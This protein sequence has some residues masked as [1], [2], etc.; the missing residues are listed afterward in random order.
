VQDAATAAI[1]AHLPDPQGPTAA[2]VVLDH[3][4][5]HVIALI[6]GRDWNASKV[7]LARGVDGGGAGRQPGSSFK[8]FVLAAALVAGFRPDDPVPAP[9]SMAVDGADHP[10][11]NY[12]GAAY[13]TLN[14]T[15]ATVHS[16]N[17]S[18]T[19]LTQQVG[20]QAV[21]DMATAL[22]IG[23]LPASGLGASIGLGAY[24]TSP[25]DMAA[26][27]S[28][29]AEDG[30][31]VDPT[32]VAR[33]VGPDGKVLVDRTAPAPGPGVLDPAFCR[34]VTDVLTQVVQR[35]TGTAAQLDRPVAGKTGTT[36]D[37][38][39]AWF[40][41]YTAEL[42]GSVWVGYADANTPMHDVSGVADVTGGS[43]PA[44]IWHDVM[45]AATQSMP[46]GA[47]PPL[48]PLPPSQRS[49]AP[50]PAVTPAAPPAPGGG[51][52]S[53]PTSGKHRKH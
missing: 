32:P 12:N 14:V 40:V 6:G 50:N 39:N 7:D 47:F 21:R 49:P 1:A 38:T 43:I 51:N 44:A 34:T 35:G 27:Y 42:T 16:V 15:E 29:I 26:A 19:W 37:Y 36:D 30:H 52:D 24:E 53:G 25:L 28:A 9:A 41:G 23:H 3:R 10:V 46:V 5:G 4:N 33:V 17:T 13:G 45:A 11:E 48:L 18:Y 2:S 8:P 20:P 22:G 31:R